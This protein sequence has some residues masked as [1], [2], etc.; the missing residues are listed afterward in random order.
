MPDV[1]SSRP[2]LH[3]FIPMPVTLG[4]VSKSFSYP[5]LATT[6]FLNLLHKLYRVSLRFPYSGTL[7]I[8]YCQFPY[9]NYEPFY[10]HTM[11]SSIS[12]LFRTQPFY[13]Y[14]NHKVTTLTK[15]F[16]S[17]SIAG[18]ICIS[19]R[20]ADPCLVTLYIFNILPKAVKFTVKGGLPI[21]STIKVFLLYYY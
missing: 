17:I 10:V 14:T 18:S 1:F 15:T 8:P 2:S 21:F 6:N 11:E 9:K 7:I 12:I 16:S 19:A 3:F 4:N 20:F 5:N 13:F